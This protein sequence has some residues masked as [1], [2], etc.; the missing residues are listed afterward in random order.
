MYL[1]HYEGLKASVRG[2]L[3]SDFE[4]SYL[5]LFFWLQRKLAG[6][7]RWQMLMKAISVEESNIAMADSEIY[8]CQDNLYIRKY[9]MGVRSQIVVQGANLEEV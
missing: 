4:D 9:Q 3:S 2:G 6:H 1:I 8:R 7:Y 5:T